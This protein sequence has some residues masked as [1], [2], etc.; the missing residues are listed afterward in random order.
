MVVIFL[1]RVPEATSTAG[2]RASLKK[3]KIKQYLVEPPDMKETAGGE[4][5][6]TNT[7]THTHTLNMSSSQ[8]ILLLLLLLVQVSF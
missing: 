5:Q 8:E 1:P 3:G 6:S 7:H 4:V 2:Q